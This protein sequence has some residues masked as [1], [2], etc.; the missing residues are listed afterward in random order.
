M[1]EC[2]GRIPAPAASYTGHPGKTDLRF[3]AELW[4]FSANFSR[5]WYPSA[6]F[7]PSCLRIPPIF[8]LKWYPH[9][10]Y[11]LKHGTP[12]VVFLP[13]CLWILPIFRP[14]SAHHSAY[15]PPNLT[16]IFRWFFCLA[17]TLGRTR[18]CHL[19][20]PR[21]C[22]CKPPAASARHS[23]FERKVRQ[24]AGYNEWWVGD[25]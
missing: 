9:P 25:G 3:W 22:N 8:Y 2:T 1:L 19:R 13:T 16:L 24:E 14:C 12:S 20:I 21:G 5:W 11:K 7:P 23:H 15:F 6:I 10:C 17:G 4:L 18:W